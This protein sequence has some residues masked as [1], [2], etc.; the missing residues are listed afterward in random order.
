M[1]ITLHFISYLLILSARKEKDE[2]KIVLQHLFWTET[3]V[4]FYSW[5][6]YRNGCTL[7]I[8]LNML[9]VFTAMEQHAV[10]YR[11]NEASWNIFF[12]SLN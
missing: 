5:P 9:N 11:M 1:I 3:T 6:L 12:H 8:L 10:K 4:T 2:Q 7:L